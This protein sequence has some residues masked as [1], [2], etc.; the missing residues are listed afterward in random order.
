MLASILYP[1][2][3]SDDETENPWSLLFGWVLVEVNEFW[4]EFF[5]YLVL[6][7]LYEYFLFL[8]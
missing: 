3:V 7:S 5:C 8:T 4:I 1:F 2:F 6:F